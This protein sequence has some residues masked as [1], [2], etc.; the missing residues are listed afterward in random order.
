MPTAKWPEPLAAVASKPRSG[1]KPAPPC[2]RARRHFITR[3][4]A[5]LLQPYLARATPAERA[6]L[7]AG[8]SNDD[9][10][11]ASRAVSFGPGALRQV[12]NPEI[13]ALLQRLLPVPR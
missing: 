9:V 5:S 7:M 12:S 2:A 4:S 11:A 13:R 1:P 3:D 6:Q 10:G 8:M